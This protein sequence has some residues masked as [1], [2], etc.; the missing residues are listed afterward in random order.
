MALSAEESQKLLDAIQNLNVSAEVIQ[1]VLQLIRNAGHTGAV[2]IAEHDNDPNAHVNVPNLCKLYNGQLMLGSLGEIAPV[3]WSLLRP[4]RIVRNALHSGWDLSLLGETK[5]SQIIGGVAG[6]K[7]FIGATT[8]D[9]KA[10]SL[11]EVQATGKVSMLVTQLRGSF[12]TSDWEQA[13]QGLTGSFAVMTGASTRSGDIACTSGR[14]TGATSKEAPHVVMYE[15][16]PDAILPWT[17]ITA[18]L[19]TA[20]YP[21]DNAYL[22]NAATVTSDERLKTSV[23]DVDGDKALALLKALRPVTFTMQVGKTEVVAADEDGNPTDIRTVPGARR[24][25]GLIAQEVR[26]ALESTGENPSDNGLWCL[27]DPTDPNSKQMLR[28]EELI[29]PM[30]KVIQ[31]QQERIEALEAKLK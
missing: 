2:D 12:H 4:A 9:N 26:A 15:L 8:A 17:G 16:G 18:S 27:A 24:H 29:A 22:K 5:G 31:M 20:M 21:F 14:I 19:G 25:A 1:E 3:Y 13:D 7:A 6:I 10:M 30:L 23:E 11:D 28:Y